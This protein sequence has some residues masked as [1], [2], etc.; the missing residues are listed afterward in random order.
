MK[1]TFDL[2]KLDW[3]VSGW[4]PHF[5]RLVK[6][7]ELGNAAQAEIPP[8]PAQVPGS[9][10]QALRTAGKLPNWN[11]GLRSLDCEWVE[12]RHWVY[13]T[14]LPQEWIAAAKSKHVKLRCEGL[15]YCGTVLLNGLEIG[16]FCGSFVPHT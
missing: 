4:M 3:R 14:T 13:E 2:S 16:T 10:Q 15:D 7:M 8:V 12:N 11:E 9:V 1:Q 6:S 5:W